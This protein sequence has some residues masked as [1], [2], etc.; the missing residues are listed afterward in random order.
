MIL[1]SDLLCMLFTLFLQKFNSI[2]ETPASANQF[3]RRD[4]THGQ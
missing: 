2:N 1:K 3:V 4:E